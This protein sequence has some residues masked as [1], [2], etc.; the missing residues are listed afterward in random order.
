[1]YLKVGQ[2]GTYTHLKASQTCLN[3]NPG[4]TDLKASQGET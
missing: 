3:T 4:E 1:M 2:G